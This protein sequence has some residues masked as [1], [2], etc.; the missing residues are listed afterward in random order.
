[1]TTY[2]NPYQGLKQIQ[3]FIDACN[4]CRRN[5]PKSL[6]GIETHQLQFPNLSANL[7]GRNQPKSL[8]GIETCLPKQHRIRLSGLNQ[9]KSLSGIET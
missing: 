2:L 4:A 8:S 5:Q 1:M 9:P 7:S 6:S 3:N